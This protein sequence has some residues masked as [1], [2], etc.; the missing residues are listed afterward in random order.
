MPVVLWG[1]GKLFF[2][3]I[4]FVRL[5]PSLIFHSMP[6]GKA[7]DSSPT[8]NK[9]INAIKA[10]GLCQEAEVGTSS[11]LCCAVFLILEIFSCS[12]VSIQ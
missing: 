8:G 6:T 4:D 7:D 12:D 10:T 3:I 11:A 9:G 1:P 5:R 2:F